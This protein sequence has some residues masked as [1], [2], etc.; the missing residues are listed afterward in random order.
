MIR[1]PAALVPYAL[2]IAA[3]VAGLLWHAGDQTGRLGASVSS[4]RAEI[5][6]TFALTDQDGKTRTDADFRGRFMLVYFGYSYCPDVCPTTL[7]M[8]SAALTKLGSRADRIV[9]VFVTIDPARD[10]P[11][12]LK[13]YLASFGPDFVGLT[14]TDKQI[15]SVAHAYHVYF[16]KHPL[17]GGNYAM[18]HSGVIYLMGPDGRFVTYYEDE[19]GPDKLAA[20]L[21][22]RL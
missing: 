16:A 4:G 10:R 13:T 7:A 18:D 20:D 5:G 17:A 3:I 21:D 1:T 8:M 15:E 11:S 2:M 14:G 22:K 9:P 19:I 6:G 12:V